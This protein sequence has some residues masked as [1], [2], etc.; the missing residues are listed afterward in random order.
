[1]THRYNTI[2]P[3]TG[4]VVASFHDATNEEIAEALDTAESCYRDWRSRPL[5]ERAAVV[6]K[7]AQLYREREDELAHLITLEMG[8]P[9]QQAR[10]EIRVSA[11]ILDYYA[12]NA[13]N[14][15]ADEPIPVESG[16]AYVRSEPVGVLLGVMPWN[17]PH[18]QVAR[19]AGPNLVL[20]N[21]ILVKHAANCPQSAQSIEQLFLDAGLPSGGYRNLFATHEQTATI[22]ADQRLQGVSLTGSERAGSII[23]EQAGRHL[24]KVVLEL[25]GN[26]PFIVLDDRDFDETVKAAVSGRMSNAGQ[27]CTSPKRFIVH[28]SVY[29]R[30]VSAVAQ[31]LLE[32]EPGDP[33]RPETKMGPVSTEGARADLLEQIGDAVTR[34]ATLIH[35]GTEGIG[36]GSFL[37]PTLLADVAPGMRAWSEELFGP[38]GIVHKVASPDHAIELANDSPYGLGAAIFGGDSETARYVAERLEAGMVFIGGNTDSE[39][40]L[41]FGGIKLSGFGRELG[42]RGMDEFA[43]KKLIRIV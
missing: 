11:R 30:F 38:V 39:P 1:M 6:A 2:N 17:Y 5:S 27:A 43:N 9:I 23:A 20:G 26:D 22:I 25:G 33:M 3:A 32:F 24:K 8:K 12:Q 7:A 29:E 36:E 14:F 41:P 37:M 18:Y 40:E 13:E 42:P 35:G 31:G 19:F 34:G 15:L 10:G 16:S 21:T 28:E 4:E